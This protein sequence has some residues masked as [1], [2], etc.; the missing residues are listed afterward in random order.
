MTW[1]RGGNDS[2]DSSDLRQDIHS[3]FRSL[4][5]SLTVARASHIEMANVTANI[6]RC[7]SRVVSIA[8]SYHWK[9]HS[10]DGWEQ[11]KYKTGEIESEKNI[12]R[13]RERESWFQYKCRAWMVVETV[14]SMRIKPNAPRVIL[15]TKFTSSALS[16]HWTLEER[17]LSRVCTAFTLPH[18]SFYEPLARMGL[19]RLVW[20]PLLQLLEGRHTL[21][22]RSTIGH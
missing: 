17:R 6:Q 20:T 11:L 15:T 4:A 3:L 19:A 7:N 9:M 2:N 1:V 14:M 12:K 8:N 18:D 5:N 16:W 13:K 10:V 22:H 21:S